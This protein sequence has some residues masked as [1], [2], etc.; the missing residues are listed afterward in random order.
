MRDVIITMIVIGA[1]PFILVRP[2][3]GVLMWTWLGLMNPHRLAWGFATHLP[4]AFMVFAVTLLGMLF[5][6]TPRQWPLRIELVVLLLF[7]G[8]M[9]V[10]T[11]QALF[12]DAAWFEWSKI[13]RIQC[14]ILI[15]LMLTRER[16]Q[17]HWLVWTIA[18]SLGFY[19]VKGGLWTVLHGGVNRVYGPAGGFIGGNN[20]IGLALLMTAP[21][22]WFLA[23]HT[24]H[25]RVRQGL[26]LAV[27]LT[28]IAVVGTHSRGAFLGMLV[29][30]LMLFIKARHKWLPAL[31]A[32]SFAVLLPVIAPQSW[33]DRMQ[34]IGAY[35][36]DNSAMGRIGAWQKAVE[37]AGERL[38]GGGFEVLIH[39]YQRDAHSIY[40][41]VLAEHGYVGLLLFLGLLV[42]A[43]RRA[44]IIR[45]RAARHPDQQWA[46]DL[47]A[48]VQVSLAGYMTA[49]A[50]L[51]LAYFDFF[52]L[53]L[54]LLVCLDAEMLRVRQVGPRATPMALG[55]WMPLAAKRV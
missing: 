12:P 52:Y 42:L 49:G 31:L 1:L 13:W 48:M 36:Q 27:G 14:G 44:R 19:G 35:E 30:G 54:A 5:S 41:E 9:L 32:M 15:T 55:G 22:I 50:F 53:L 10:S 16:Q 4:F 40:F 47:A 8:W 23:L 29:M 39:S 25:P 3:L 24:A 28:L 51:G 38:T 21:L 34:T 2:F 43:W 37:I 46:G 7:L 20:E 18:V 11:S 17:I 33:F 6:R 45:A 26:Y